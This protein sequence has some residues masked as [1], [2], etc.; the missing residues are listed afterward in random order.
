MWRSLL[1]GC[2][3]AFAGVWAGWALHRVAAKA[4]KKSEEEIGRHSLNLAEALQKA[5]VF[6]SLVRD[7]M[8][9]GMSQQE[10]VDAASAIKEREMEVVAVTAD[11]VEVLA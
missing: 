9:Q 11:G 8:R 2:T 7:L 3:V 6:E 4:M 1:I 5:S 10:A